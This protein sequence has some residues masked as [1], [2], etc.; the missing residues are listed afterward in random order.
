MLICKS[1]FDFAAETQI[2]GS[3]VLLLNVN[4]PS[5]FK[6]N[7]YIRLIRTNVGVDLIRLADG[8]NIDAIAAEFEFLKTATLAEEYAGAITTKATNPYNNQLA[9]ARRVIG[10][11]SGTFLASTIRNG[12]MSKEDKAIL[13][14]VV[15]PVKNVGWFSGL[16][17]GQSSQIGTSL[18]CSGNVVSAVV[19]AAV[20]ATE[21]SSVR[22]TV[23][24][25][26]TGLNYYVRIHVES[27]PSKCVAISNSVRNYAL[28]LYRR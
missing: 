20:G 8:N 22:V 27:E 14:G 5:D 2:K 11:D 6:T 25:A 19:Y 3:G 26:M 15:N 24:N 4:V 18:P 1:A 7:D 13:D 9:F 17:I 12:L 16:D 21:E 10:L 23:A 28:N